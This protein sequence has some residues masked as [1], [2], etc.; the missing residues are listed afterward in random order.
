MGLVRPG[1]RRD[2]PPSTRPCP[3]PGYGPARGT[4]G[5]PQFGGSLTPEFHPRSHRCP[6]ALHPAKEGFRRQVWS[7]IPAFWL[8]RR[9]TLRRPPLVPAGRD[10]SPGGSS[11]RLRLRRRRF[12]LDRRSRI[13]RLSS[14]PGTSSHCGALASSPLSR[15]AGA[16]AALLDP[17]AGFLC[18]EGRWSRS[19]R[20]L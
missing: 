1:C 11:T 15:V 13:E 19:T 5:L 7:Q 16:V 20:R 12:P 18:C 14:G 4:I 3:P 8:R 17:P 10:P 2:S 9:G 6:E